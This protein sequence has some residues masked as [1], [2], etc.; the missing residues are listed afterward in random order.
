[1]S[2]A[3]K[4]SAITLRMFCHTPLVNA[5]KHERLA[6]SNVRKK[7]RKPHIKVRVVRKRGQ[8]C[9]SKEILKSYERI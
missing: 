5:H 2:T 9:G 3:L 6:H 4:R 1:M 8:I 7:R